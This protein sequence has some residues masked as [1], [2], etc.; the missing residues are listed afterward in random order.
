MEQFIDQKVLEHTVRFSFDDG[1]P[2]DPRVWIIKQVKKC[3]SLESIQAV[4]KVAD[5]KWH[6]TL[7]D[8]D[9]VN[10]VTSAS[11]DLLTPRAS[12]QR[13]DRRTVNLRINWLPIWIDMT[14]VEQ[15]LSQL[16]VIKLCQRETESFEGVNFLN[17]SI[18]VVLDVS[19]KDFDRIPYKTTIAGRSVLLTVVGRPPL[20]LK[21]KEVGHNRRDCPSSKEKEK[22]SSA[23]GGSGSSQS[24]SQKKS[25]VVPP[26]KQSENVPSYATEQSSVPEQSGSWA[27]SPMEESSFDVNSCFKDSQQSQPIKKCKFDSTSESV[28][29]PIETR[30]ELTFQPKFKYIGVE[31]F[32]SSGNLMGKFR[33]PD[34]AVEK[35][36]KLPKSK[37]YEYA[38]NKLYPGL[39][40]F[41]KYA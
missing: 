27:A 5:G 26:E 25:V 29:E 24:E 36:M 22:A 10:R 11:W 34:H 35:M 41:L 20:C 28:L 30:V 7:N 21:C 23:T 13:C 16:G 18:K 4:F 38:S 17:G 14:A 19:E 12:V 33:V 6:V 9:S 39:D 32:D 3:T 2:D 1:F 37:H 40:V 8:Q 31:K 15:Y